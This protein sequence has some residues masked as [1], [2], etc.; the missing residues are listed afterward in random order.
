[1]CTSKTF[2]EGEEVAP[3]KRETIRTTK[4]KEENA[5]EDSSESGPT[6]HQLFELLV[7]AWINGERLTDMEIRKRFNI[8]NTEAGWSG[9][10]KR[11]KQLRLALRHYYLG[12][13]YDPAAGEADSIEIGLNRGYNIDVW[14]RKSVP[15][16]ASDVLATYQHAPVVNIGERINSADSDAI[17]RVCLTGFVDMVRFGDRLMKALKRSVPMEFLFPHPDSEFVEQRAA[18]CKIDIKPILVT[19]RETLR[20][21]KRTAETQLEEERQPI[22]KLGKLTLRWTSGWI[23]LPYVQIGD[24]IYISAFWRDEPVGHGPFFLLD[25]SSPTG[26]FLVRQF[27]A[28]WETASE[29]NL[30]EADIPAMK[31][32]LLISAS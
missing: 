26:D 20:E 25:A 10:R 23:P 24:A 6:L 28:V 7:N 19:N 29:D 31:E 8:S 17:I 4:A 9:I 32:D 14:S 3:K 27:G 16:Q 22:T 11:A 2:L 18:G 21:I 5:D 15:Q 1:M 12:T 30:L 13:Q